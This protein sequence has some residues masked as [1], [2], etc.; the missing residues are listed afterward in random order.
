MCFRSNEG[1]RDDEGNDDYNKV[2]CATMHFVRILSIVSQ[3]E[4][5]DSVSLLLYSWVCYVVCFCD[6][7]VDRTHRTQECVKWIEWGRM[8]NSSNS[9]FFTIRKIKVKQIEWEIPK[10]SIIC[11]RM[12][13]WPRYGRTNSIFR[14]PNGNSMN[15]QS[16]VVLDFAAE[17]K[18]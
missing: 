15:D 11:N 3:C 1:E 7:S 8:R 10:I 12:V 13:G 5:F 14:I 18:Q 4:H 6:D 17:W 2:W 16:G 9:Q